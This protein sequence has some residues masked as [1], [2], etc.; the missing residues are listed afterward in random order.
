[1]TAFGLLQTDSLEDRSLKISLSMMHQADLHKRG[2]ED[3]RLQNTV[4]RKMIIG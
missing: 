3:W 1:M 2:S 4:T